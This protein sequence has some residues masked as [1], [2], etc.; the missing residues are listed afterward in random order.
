VHFELHFSC[1][2]GG[3]PCVLGHVNAKL[4]VL[5]QR[6]LE[7]INIQVERGVRLAVVRDEAEA[8]SLE[9]AYE[10][11]LVGDEPVSL[12]GLVEDE[13]ILAMP[14]FPR[15]SG[16]ECRMPMGADALDDAGAG[17]ESRQDDRAGKS[18]EDNPFSVLESIKSRTTP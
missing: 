16:G 5:C 2:D 13:L 9:A 10:V 14:D 8:E 12:A 6:C 17:G 3:Q 7:P 11:L 18:G 1:D 15:H 4:A